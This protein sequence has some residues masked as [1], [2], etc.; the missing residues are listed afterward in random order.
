MPFRKLFILYA[1]EWIVMVV[2]SGK[3]RLSPRSKGELAKHLGKDVSVEFVWR[4]A[5]HLESGTLNNLSEKTLDFGNAS[6]P[7]E[8]ETSGIQFVYASD[9]H[10]IYLNPRIADSRGSGISTVDLLLREQER[11]LMKME[12][13]A[14]CDGLLFR[15]ELEAEELGFIA[16]V[17]IMPGCHCQGKNLED[18][19]NKIADVIQGHIDFLR[20]HGE[21]IPKE[22]LA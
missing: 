1:A 5:K 9:G 8:A 13:L 20:K 17:P 22:D 6:L 18:A 3:T 2:D 16:K 14:S 10:I 15:V 12:K 19:M 21:E 4:G 11:P 7:F